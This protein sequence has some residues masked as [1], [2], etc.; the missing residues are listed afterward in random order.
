M[1]ANYEHV[2][3]TWPDQCPVP[4]GDEALAGARRLVR[5]ALTLGPPGQPVRK[6]AGKFQL[7]SGNRRCWTRRGVFYVNPDNQSFGSGFAGWKGIV[8]DISHWAGRRLFPKHKPHDPRHAYLERQLAELVVSDGWL[9][10]KLKRPEKAKPTIE[11]V[12]RKRYEATKAALERWERKEKRAR[13]AI[14]K[15]ELRKRYYEKQL[16]I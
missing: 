16:S 15:L 7:T 1:A 3:A 2:N 9:D 6:F 10:G 8:H 14:R 5:L 4:S 13:T 11:D 12:K